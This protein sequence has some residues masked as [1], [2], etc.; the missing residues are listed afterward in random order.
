MS[1]VFALLVVLLMLSGC[2]GDPPPAAPGRP[3]PSP[4]AAA[5]PV[6]PEKATEDSKA[7]AI[8]FVQHYVQLLNYAQSTGDTVPLIAISGSGCKSCTRVRG[9]I[10]EIYASGG[11]IKGGNLELEID[12]AFA[13]PDIDGWS[14]FGVVR[15]EPSTVLQGERSPQQLKGGSG[16]V[17]YYV[18]LAERGPEMIRWTRES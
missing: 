13:K 4:T 14:I 12:L 1:R 9:A 11:R 7:G 16:P 8:A 10:D 3:S 17:T 15:F 18:R 6:M 2:G 5:V